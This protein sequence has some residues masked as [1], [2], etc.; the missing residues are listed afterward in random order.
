MARQVPGTLPTAIVSAALGIVL[1]AGCVWAAGPWSGGQR[2]SERADASRDGAVPVARTSQGSLAP[3]SAAPSTRS[4]GPAHV[5]AGAA[6]SPVLAGD[7]PGGALTAAELAGALQPLTL[8]PG[9]GK[10]VGI[11]VADPAS[12]ALLFDEHAADGFAPASTNKVVTAVAALSALGPD[13][14]F[15]TRVVQGPDSAATPTIVLVGGG[16]PT[17]STQGPSSDPGYQPASLDDLAAR[18]AAALQAKGVKSV[19]LGYDASVFSG[20]GL[21]PTWSPDYTDG[22]VA[23]VT[24]LMVDEGRA[25]AANDLSPRVTDPAALAAVDFAGRLAAHG[26]QV[27]GKPA[28]ASAGSG[29]E[30][31]RVTSP[32]LANLVEHMLTV[33]DN[34]LAESLLRHVALADSKPATFDGGVAAVR[35]QLG[36]LGLD[37]TGLNVLDGSGL[38]RKD[39]ITPA[40]EVKVL[41]TAAADDHPELRAALTG[42]P[43]AGFTGTLDEDGRYTTAPSLAGAGLVRAKTGSLT[44]VVTL[45]GLVRDSSGQLLVFSLMADEA[46][47]STAARAAVDRLATTLAGC[48]CGGGTAPPA[49]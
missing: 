21:N 8:A 30:L 4:A 22:N 15:A 13:D 45:A 46:T 41:S 26:V 18:T 40:F 19:T 12:P 32:R 10:H 1:A 2:V 31:A 29:A 42:L 47:D 38:S 37:L 25:K 24:G 34:D 35:D 9:L 48:G 43:V 36:K 27:T 3:S 49:G 23:P 28:T 16:D 5:P 6:L 11:A 44:G 17:L 33:S 20:P 39:S 14:R 7:K